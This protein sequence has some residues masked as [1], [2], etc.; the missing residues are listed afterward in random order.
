[1]GTGSRIGGHAKPIEIPLD[2]L[3]FIM[4]L[5]A[6]HEAA[7]CHRVKQELKLNDGGKSIHGFPE[8]YRIHDQ[9]DLRFRLE[10]T[11]IADAEAPPT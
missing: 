7:G 10:T 8:I 9:V 2:D 5:V 6:E 4:L 1:M 11:V 3:D